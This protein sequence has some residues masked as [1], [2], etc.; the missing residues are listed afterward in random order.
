MPS[1]SLK[2]GDNSPNGPNAGANGGQDAQSPGT[3]AKKDYK[4]PLCEAEGGHPRPDGKSPKSVARCPKFKSTPAGER[5]KL[6]NSINAC[7]YCLQ[8]T[9]KCD[10]CKWKTDT[11]WLVHDT[12]TDL[13][14]KLVCPSFK[15]ERQN[16]TSTSSSTDDSSKLIVNLAENV[17]LKDAANVSHDAIAIYDSCSDSSWVSSDLAKHFPQAR[18]Q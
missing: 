13:H 1:T 3:G 4:C 9:H 14:N 12:C 15:P 18:R 16:A 7:I 2:L 10:S 8:T 17:Q 6:V 5:I 11:Q